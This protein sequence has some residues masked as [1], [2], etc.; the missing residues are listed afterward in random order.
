MTKRSFDLFLACGGLVLLSPVLIIV[1]ALV[2]LSSPGP[3]LYTQE[4]IGRRL[5]PFLIYKFRTMQVGCDEGGG[6]IAVADDSRVAAV[7]RLLRQTR[8]DELP[9]LWNVLKG[10]MSIVGSRPELP[11]YVA[12]FP[13]D[14]AEI[15]QARPGLTDLA[16]LK[17]REEAVLLA[18]AEDPESEYVNRILPDKIRLA[19][20][21]IHRSSVFFDLAVIARTLLQ[22]FGKHR[23]PFTPSREM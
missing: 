17:Y 19:R 13:D 21:S 6:A 18:H 15:L 16:T 3:A 2:K 7:G 8:L 4:R 10:D 20:E 22:M 9:Q 5:R 1:A 23:L 14:Y 12:L 11:R